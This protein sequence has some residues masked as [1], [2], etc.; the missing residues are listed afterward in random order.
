MGKLEDAKRIFESVL[1]HSSPTGLLS[2]EMYPR[3]HEMLGNYPQGFTHI[4][5]IHAALSMNEAIQKEGGRV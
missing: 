4:G 1:G 3:S 2:E 5:L